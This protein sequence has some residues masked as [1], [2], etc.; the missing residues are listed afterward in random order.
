MFWAKAM[1][2]CV[3]RDGV[4]PLDHRVENH[5]ETDKNLPGEFVREGLTCVVSVSVHVV[6]ACHLPIQD[7]MQGKISSAFC[8]LFFLLVLPC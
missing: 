6:S 3:L 2:V 1:A 8:K 4:Q 5:K 7:C